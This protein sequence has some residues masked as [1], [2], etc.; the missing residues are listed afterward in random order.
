VAGDPREFEQGGLLGPRH[1]LGMAQRHQV[2][3]EIEVTIGALEAAVRA[4]VNRSFSISACGTSWNS[5]VAPID[6]TVWRPG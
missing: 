2:T 1:G 4:S 6:W 5:E 3:P